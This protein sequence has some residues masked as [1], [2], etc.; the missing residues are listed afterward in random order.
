MLLEVVS[1]LGEQLIV[2]RVVHRYL[3]ANLARSVCLL[4]NVYHELG[5]LP[6]RTDLLF[7]EVGSLRIRFENRLRG[8]DTAAEKSAYVKSFHKVWCP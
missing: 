8:T 5:G 3:I 2:E 1:G 6:L 4:A 7:I